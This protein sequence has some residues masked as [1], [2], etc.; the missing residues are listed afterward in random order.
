MADA[1]IF[2]LSTIDSFESQTTAMRKRAATD[3][4]M[5]ETA[6]RLGAKFDAPR[7]SVTVGC[8]FGLGGTRAIEQGADII[9]TDFAVF[10]QHMLRRF[11]TA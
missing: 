7:R 4:D 8:L 1:D 5:T 11:R 6:I 2:H 9:A 3:S 10:N